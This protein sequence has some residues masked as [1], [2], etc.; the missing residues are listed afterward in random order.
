MN[1]ARSIS[2]SVK[3]QMLKT[4]GCNDLE[5]KDKIKEDIGWTLGV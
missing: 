4:S 5:M 3:F 2:Q 1:S